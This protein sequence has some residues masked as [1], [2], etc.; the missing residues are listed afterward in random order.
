MIELTK[1]EKFNL[2]IILMK[3]LRGDWSNSCSE[4]ANK[5]KELATELNYPKTVKL[6]NLYFKFI[7]EY[8]D[9]DGRHFRT[10]WKMFGGYENAPD[11]LKK[12]KSLSKKY[13]QAIIENCNHPDLRLNF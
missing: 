6:V 11:K 5:V 9:T 2:M 1:N 7:K 10:S 13:I 12:C 3:D 4:R 8:G